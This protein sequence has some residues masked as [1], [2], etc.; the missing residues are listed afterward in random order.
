[1][2]RALAFALAV[3][4]AGP[5]WAEGWNSGWGQG[6]AEAIISDDDGNSIYVACD[7]GYGGSSSISFTLSGDHARGGTV[8][9]LFDGE[10]HY[11]VNVDSMGRLDDNDVDF[12]PTIS[13]LESS[14]QVTFKFGGESATFSLEGSARAIQTPC[15]RHH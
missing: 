10:R 5:V 2:I 1:M 4:A 9:L 8:H 14:R 13:R 11:Q 12:A 3:F 6:V 7:D 15:G